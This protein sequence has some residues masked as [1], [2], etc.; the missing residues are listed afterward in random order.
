MVA[1][2]APLVQ[3]PRRVFWLAWLGHVIGAAAGGALLGAVL[4]FFGLLIHPP[5]SWLPLAALLFVAYALHEIG[6]VRLPL[7]SFP[8]AVPFSWRERFGRVRAAW[9]YGFALSFGFTGRTPYPTFHALLVLVVLIA[10]PAIGAAAV[11]AYG[12]SRG[13]APLLAATTFGESAADHLLRILDAPQRVHTVNAM[14]L[15]FAGPLLVLAPR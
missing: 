4:G 9:L 2:I 6:A 14:A 11:A 3:G 8:T 12:I 10:S 15:A 7:A 1:T 13:F 5:Q